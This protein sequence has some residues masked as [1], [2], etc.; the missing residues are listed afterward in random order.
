[1]KGGASMKHDS[2]YAV[3]DLETTGTNS[4]EDKIIQI[5]C[6]FV[7]NGQIIDTYRQDINPRIKLT[8]QIESLT[9][10]TNEQLARAPY[11]ED[12]ASDLWQKLTN[13][14]FVAHNIYFDYQFLSQAF[15]SVGFEPLTMPGIDTVEL[16]QIFLPTLPSYRLSD[17]ADFLDYQHDRPHQ[18]DS[19]A[20]VTGELFIYIEQQIRQVPIST[21][22]QIVALS[23]VL[24][25]ETSEFLEMQL[26]KLKASYPPLKAGIKV[27]NGLALRQKVDISGLYP[28]KVLKEFPLGVESKTEAYGD[29]LEVRES[30]SRMMDD[31]YQFFTENDQKSFNKNFAIEA[32]TGSGKSFGY[33][34]PM[35]F[36]ATCDNPVVLSTTS[37]L[38]EQQLVNE[39]IPLVNQVNHESL[40]GTMIKSSRYFI[41]LNKFYVTLQQ[42]VRQKQFAIHQ[43]SVL[44]WL[45]ETETGDLTELN[46]ANLD[47]PFFRQIKHFG[48]RFVPVGSPFY[49]EDFWRYL[50][51]RVKHSNVLIVNHAFLIKENFREFPW[52]PASDYLIIDE[53]H[54]LPEI[55][56]KMGREELDFSKIKFVLH[57]LTNFEEVMS[58]WSYIQQ[59]KDWP[60][61][62]QLMEQIVTEANQVL[63]NLEADIVETT[64][65]DA[66]LKAGEELLISQAQLE[67]LPIYVMQ[68]IYRFIRLL[69][70]LN[71]LMNQ[72]RDF[73]FQHWD[74]WLPSEQLSIQAWLDYQE[75]L[76]MILTFVTDYIQNDD[77]KVIK[78][79]YI[80]Q[81]KYQ[82]RLF[83][84]DVGASLV[85][86]TT[87]YERYKKILYTGG[88]LSTGG[89]DNFLAKNL[90][91]DDIPMEKFKGTFD[92][93]KQARLYLPSEG[94][95]FTNLSSPYYENY[96]AQ[97]ILS[98]A[99]NN[100]VN[101]LVLFTSLE[102]LKNVYHKIQPT[103]IDNSIETLAQG[104]TGSRERIL[105]RFT[106]QG[107]QKVLLGADSYWEGV[108][109][110]GDALELIVVVRLP[111]ESPDRPYIKEKLRLYQERGLD[112]FQY[113]S[114]PKAILRLRQGVGRLIRTNDDTG[115]IVMLDPRIKTARYSKKIQDSLPEGLDLI[116]ETLDEINQELTHFIGKG[117]NR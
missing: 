82:I 31:V 53:A 101:V 40:V 58:N 22:E 49:E 59:D 33:L 113:Y 107:G 41:D 97:S 35:S 99:K 91:I 106:K 34:Y 69:A 32:P 102:M 87:W 79:L 74:K 60:I 104:I 19:D 18:A 95:H 115:A 83:K 24:G 85:E 17:I 2:V 38:L 88:T 93:K 7:Q 80:D 75:E 116:I 92:Y 73:C 89:Q 3:V 66:K 8:K 108:D 78:W 50:K 15:V 45:L 114:L 20:L 47:H 117:N 27:V 72:C 94:M 70:D 30:Q 68:D 37:I 76:G 4:K 43:M 71:G 109:L 56:E 28:H 103:L 110:P 55:A 62:V 57:K 5:G 51:N 16:G 77:E 14:V 12:I 25:R 26:A 65:L 63:E 29:L 9:G 112:G 61:N 111:F 100:A 96:V 52:L 23:G 90:G 54:H 46:L 39:A 64:L 1:M 81:D 21:L 98:L 11:F 10:L 13:C 86:E 44:V 67:N 42:P 84:S 36:L 48:E 105:K 6:V